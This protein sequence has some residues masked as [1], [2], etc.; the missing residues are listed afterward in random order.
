MYLIQTVPSID[1]PFGEKVASH[2]QVTSVFS[3]LDFM[4][5]EMLCH[6]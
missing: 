1:K 4:S 3:Q 2:F 5:S 6:R